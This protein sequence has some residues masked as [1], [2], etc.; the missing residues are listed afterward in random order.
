MGTVY[1]RGSKHSPKWW[2]GYKDRDG[3]WKYGPSNQPTKE[4]ARRYL[5]QVEGNV[6]GDR[7]G[8]EPVGTALLCGSL[9]DDWSKGLTNRNAAD[10]RYRLENHLRPA[11]GDTRIRDISLGTIMAWLEAQRDGTAPRKV[12]K[13]KATKVAAGF[14]APKAKPKEPARLADGSIRHN[15]NL[16]SRFLGWCVERGHAEHNPTRDIPQG[17]RPA[18]AIKRDVPWLD[19]DEKVVE[20]MKALP[21]HIALMFYLATGAACVRARS[22]G[23]RSPTSPILAKGTIRVRYSYDGPLKEDKQ[24]VG[25]VKWVPA[26]DDAETVFEKHMAARK[27]AKAEPE[28]FLF[29]C[30]NREG[31]FYRK[32]F[33]EK[34]WEVATAKCG[35]EL[36]WYEATR[37]SFVSR[38]LTN[39][40]TLDEV[41]AAVGHSSPIVTRR[42]YDHFVRKEFSDK[43]RA[44]LGFNAK[45]KAKKRKAG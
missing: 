17:K 44:G 33:I 13:P 1:N 45:P 7:V 11:F 29:A 28:D 37:H 39:G 42:Y 20:L 15:L 35:V 30:A 36:T 14:A 5:V 12:K 43:L 40:A 4:Q 19:D 41:S 21:E 10:D 9:L 24:G 27:A 6:A 23:S 38:T 18:Q 22:R 25:K 34:A 26:P 8:I 2:I 16:L 3:E 32:E 31:S